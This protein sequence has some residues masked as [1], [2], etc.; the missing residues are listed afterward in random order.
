VRGK[1][2]FQVE[3]GGSFNAQDVLY[4]PGLKKNFFLV[5]TMEDMGFVITF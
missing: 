5:S 3:S 2:I 4:I 1:V